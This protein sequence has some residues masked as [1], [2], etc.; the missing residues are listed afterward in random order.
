V[1][2]GERREWLHQDVHDLHFF[3]IHFLFQLH[4]FIFQRVL[5][6]KLQCMPW[7]HFS[8]TGTKINCLIA[9]WLFY[10]T[11]QMSNKL[12]KTITLEKKF[13]ILSFFEDK[14]PTF[15]C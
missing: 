5:R 1:T 13:K 12:P 7:V 3:S 4:A 8:F 14:Q 10:P 2:L 11:F 9:H 6:C 15:C